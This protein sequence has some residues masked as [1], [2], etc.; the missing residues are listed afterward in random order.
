MRLT[1]LHRFIGLG[2]LVA[3][4]VAV[5]ATFIVVNFD[6]VRLHQAQGR[7]H[8]LGSCLQSE[9]AREAI[10]QADHHPRGTRREGGCPS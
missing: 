7:V 4:I 9:L 6:L 5:P 3:I 1:W 8:L 2:V 10:V